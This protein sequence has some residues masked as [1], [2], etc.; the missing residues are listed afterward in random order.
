[1]SEITE[2]REDTAIREENTEKTPNITSGNLTARFG[3]K[4]KYCNA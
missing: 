3:I 4:T 2:A 1:M